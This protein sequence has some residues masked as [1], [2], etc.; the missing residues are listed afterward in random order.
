VFGAIGFGRAGL[1]QASSGTARILGSGLAANH[2]GCAGR[3]ADDNA[4]REPWH[5]EVAVLHRLVRSTTAAD[6]RAIATLYR[7]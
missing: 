3:A 4:P 1:I 6:L 2:S 5:E 7:T